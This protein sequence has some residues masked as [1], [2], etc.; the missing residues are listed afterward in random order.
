[1]KD[2]TYVSKEVG[3]VFTY[4]AI[5]E[6]EATTVQVRADATDI[7]T[8]VKDTL[9]KFTYDKDGYGKKVEKLDTDTI[10]ANMNTAGYKA[11]G[12]L[13]L[14]AP[15]AK[16]L[17]VDGATLYINDNRNN[18]KY[19][20]LDD[21]CNF[22]VKVND[23]NNKKY[24]TDGYEEFVDVDAALAALGSNQYTGKL[25]AVC[26]K[27]SGYATTVI[28]YDTEYVDG[29]AVGGSTSYVVGTPHLSITGTTVTS[30]ADTNNY[31]YGIYGN[32]AIDGS[33]ANTALTNV[34][35]SYKV[36]TWN[37]STGT[38]N[39]PITVESAEQATVAANVY[40]DTGIAAQ[41]TLPTP[42]PANTNC[43]VTVTVTSAESTVTFDPVLVQAN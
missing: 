9:F 3:Y 20:V 19:I 28:I 7:N 14:A 8:L 37:G 29:I 18:Q 12:Y 10:A 11:A 1:M 30:T 32:A 38:W 25:V 21:E 5:I 22:F 43:M 23:S 26:D 42:V 36:S 15:T 16:T 6:G 34:V 41:A 33:G 35:V 4:D 13:K 24:N 2:K 40:V 17:Y 27:D 31:A 39:A